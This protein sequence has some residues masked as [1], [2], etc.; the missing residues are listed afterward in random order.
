[1]FTKTALYNSKMGKKD[2]FSAMFKGR[3][4]HNVAKFTNKVILSRKFFY[5]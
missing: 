3:F 1:M 4:S 5:F 2:T